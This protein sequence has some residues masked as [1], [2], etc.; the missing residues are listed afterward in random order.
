MRSFLLLAS[1]ALLPALLLGQ[2]PKGKVEPIKVIEITRKDP[3]LYDKDIEPVFVKKCLVCHSG[4]IKEGKL[5]LDSYE[6][7]MKGGKRGKSI[8]IPG[9]AE[10][11]LLYKSVG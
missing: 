2:E 11:S 3:V 10:E 1:V 8:V 9:K 4:Q 5:D 6:V 7:L